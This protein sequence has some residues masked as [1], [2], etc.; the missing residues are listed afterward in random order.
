M[1]PVLGTASPSRVLP[2]S[3]H[4][5]N[6]I[7][8]LPEPVLVNLLPLGSSK[9]SRSKKRQNNDIETPNEGERAKKRHYQRVTIRRSV[10]SIVSRVEF[11][12]IPMQDWNQPSWLDEH[13]ASK[14]SDIDMMWVQDPQF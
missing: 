3:G 5:P 14:Y 12:V 9:T 10:S 8:V 4:Q 7:E 6:G 1:P 11:G 13:K 2:T